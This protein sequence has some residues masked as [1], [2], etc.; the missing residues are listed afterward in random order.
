MYHF[1]DVPIDDEFKF[2]EKNKNLSKINTTINQ[3]FN[4]Y[5]IELKKFENYRK[6]LKDQKKTFKNQIE[7]IL[8]YKSPRG[9]MVDT[10]DLKSLPV[11]EC[12]FESGRGHQKI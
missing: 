2:D 11:R 4:N 5:T 9:E 10:K 3:I 1:E 7:E 6:K 12:Q 8:I